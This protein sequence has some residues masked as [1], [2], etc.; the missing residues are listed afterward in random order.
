MMFIA[1]ENNLVAI[2][3]GKKKAWFKVDARFYV[4]VEQNPSTQLWSCKLYCGSS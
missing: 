2:E 4:V 1:V 3:F